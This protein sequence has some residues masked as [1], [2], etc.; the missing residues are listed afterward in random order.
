MAE[1]GGSAPRV[2]GHASKRRVP[3]AVVPALL[4]L[5]VGI[6]V[7]AYGARST[8]MLAGDAR[9]DRQQHAAEAAAGAY[10]LALGRQLAE[11]VEVVQGVAAFF[12]ASAFVD[13][14]EFNAF[15]DGPL[16]RNP[17]IMALEYCLW[18]DGP[19]DGA[20]P[21]A[22]WRQREDALLH[23]RGP[24]HQPAPLTPRPFHAPILF[25]EPPTY[26]DLIGMDLAFEPQRR[27]TLEAAR[28]S[29]DVAVS[30][31]LE[32]VQGDEGFLIVV[33]VGRQAAPDGVARVDGFAIGVVGLRA[34]IEAAENN[35]RR[36]VANAPALD[37]EAVLYGT[38]ST[39]PPSGDDTALAAGLSVAAAGVP[40]SMEFRTA[41]SVGSGQMV[42]V[43]RA[44]NAAPVDYLDRSVGLV[45][46][47][48]LILTLW[49]TLWVIGQT[50]RREEIARIVDA[51]TKQLD[52]SM[53][54]LAGREAQ[55]RA[56]FETAVDG[57][58]ICEKDG[59]IV[60]ANPAARALFA[61]DGAGVLGTSL[62]DHLR[63]PLG[64]EDRVSLSDPAVGGRWVENEAIQPDGS[65]VDIELVRVGLPY[66]GG[67][68]LDLVLI[69]DIRERKQVDRLQRQFI[70]MV[71]HELRTPM[72]AVLGALD[73]IRGGAVGPVPPE[74]LR[75][76]VIA[77]TS[78]DRLVRI[79]N[80]ML[81]VEGLQA[82]RFQLVPEVV[83]LAAIVEEAVRANSAYA[84]GGGTTIEVD[85]L[86]VAQVMGDRG[87]LVQVLTNLL[88]N[89]IKF[90]PPRGWVTVG[91]WRDG[92]AWVASVADRGEGISDDFV[93][94]LFHPFARNDQSNSRRVGGTGLGLFIARAIVEGHEGKLWYEPRAGGGSVFLF[95]LPAAGQLD[96]ERP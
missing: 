57:L 23:E 41:I 59:A 52:A 29:G 75:L 12:E 34:V 93:Q 42:A 96:Q 71:N 48:G 77:S 92:D 86:P 83:D 76:V 94:R 43:A 26:A 64:R 28:A 8:A 22:I 79:I 37:V 7:T 49:S 62:A 68:M 55:L 58:L 39:P 25:V 51:R 32:L 65:S 20:N 14:N 54:E 36:S 95:A 88:S 53:Q 11:T 84:A 67:A 10:F 27:A 2:G 91:L 82:G 44:P 1:E 6:A 61:P 13:A 15:T 56:I 66:T 80:D 70:A 31:A 63:A 45:V 47:S 60:A 5:A 85:P 78:G 72:T 35:L 16:Q 17:T 46:S 69:R 4:A 18:L 24:D 50:R 30:P 87:R 21:P 73:L 9:S 81:D 90:S 33:P 3:A 38:G 74:V 89:A 19:V 40:A